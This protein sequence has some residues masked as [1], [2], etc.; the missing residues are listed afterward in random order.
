MVEPLEALA[1]VILPTIGPSVHEKLL[2]AVAVNDIFGLKPLQMTAVV[3]VV[4]AG[5]GLT[6]TTML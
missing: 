3:D 1:P 2:G 4:K 5:F 6:V